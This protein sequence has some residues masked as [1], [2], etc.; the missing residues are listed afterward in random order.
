MPVINDS[1]LLYDCSHLPTIV[2]LGIGDLDKRLDREEKAK[3]MTLE[4]LCGITPQSNR[5]LQ[6]NLQ[7]FECGM[8]LPRSLATM[9]LFSLP[10]DLRR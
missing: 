10:R 4:V 2:F 8:A 5:H 6:G 3:S 9:S 1:I 7:D